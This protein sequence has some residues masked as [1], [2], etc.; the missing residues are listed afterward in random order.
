[1]HTRIQI[2]LLIKGLLE[3]FRIFSTIIINDMRVYIGDHINLGMTGVSLYR[4]DVTA[5]QL[6]LIGNTGMAKTVEYY[7]RKIMFPDQ[8]I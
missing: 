3:E 8:V 2:L 5:I 1:M 6:K 4:L 7:R